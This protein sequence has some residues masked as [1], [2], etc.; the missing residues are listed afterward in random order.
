[1]HLLDRV[2]MKPVSEIQE[3]Q[4]SSD[5]PQASSCEEANISFFLSK[6]SPGASHQLSLAFLLIAIF[7]LRLIVH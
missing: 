6:A 5:G 1:M 2:L 4:S 3:E 7:M